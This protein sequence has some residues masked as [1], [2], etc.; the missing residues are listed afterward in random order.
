MENVWRFE[1]VDNT[2][3]PNQISNGIT[4]TLGSGVNEKPDKK[5]K[6]EKGFN[7]TFSDKIEGDLIKQYAISPL[8][9]VTGGLASPVYRAVRQIAKGPAVG[10]AVGGLVATGAMIAISAG[11]DALKNRMQKLETKVQDLNNTDNAL[12]RAGAVSKTT[13]YSANIFGIK[14]K[15]NRS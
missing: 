1:F 5:K 9:T 2:G 7:E 13:Y 8:N 12:I 15:T 3:Q 10:V 14:K 6:E 11:I 4:D